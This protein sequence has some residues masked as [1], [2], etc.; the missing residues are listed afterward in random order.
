MGVGGAGCDPAMADGVENSWN[1]KVTR[2]WW[3]VYCIWAFFL[4]CTWCELLVKLFFLLTL[5]MIGEWNRLS[6]MCEASSWA[7]ED[8]P[9]PWGG[10]WL[11]WFIHGHIPGKGA[12][13][14]QKCR[15]TSENFGRCPPPPTTAPPQEHI[16][17]EPDL[18]T[19]LW[20]PWD[21]RLA[22]PFLEQAP[23]PVSQFCQAPEGK[24]SSCF[25][26]VSSVDFTH[27][28]VS[29]RLTFLAH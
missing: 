9:C 23:F 20:H 15:E 1:N 3:G 27:S 5:Y 29:M 12:F 17:Y 25:Y 6:S 11:E 10:W 22:T 8:E 21:Y 7:P 18:R 19:V 2:T 13:Q 28:G 26:I 14:E 4:N 16:F 24:K